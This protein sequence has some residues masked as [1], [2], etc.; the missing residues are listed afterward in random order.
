M[1]R[2]V[3]VRTLRSGVTY[4]QFKAAWVPEGTAGDYPAKSWVSRNVA[5]DRQVITIVEFDVPLTEIAAAIASLVR[6]DARDRLSEII[7]SSELEAVFE[8]VFDETSL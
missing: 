2:A 8:D 1:L 3:F 6:S 4:E 5:N 7:E